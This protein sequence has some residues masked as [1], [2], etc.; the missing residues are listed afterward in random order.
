MKDLTSQRTCEVGMQV[1]CCD[2]TEVSQKSYVWQDSA[3]DR[4]DTSGFE[5]SKRHNNGRR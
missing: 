1:P 3:K 5:S 4:R 2:T